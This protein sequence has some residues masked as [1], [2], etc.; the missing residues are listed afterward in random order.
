MSTYLS[1]EQKTFIE[2]LWKNEGK[3]AVKIAEELNLSVWTVRRLIQR[4]KKT[5]LF[6]P[7]WVAPIAE[8]ETV[9]LLSYLM[10]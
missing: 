7:K 3:N 8:Q 10:R 1:M 2:N 9:L 5:I 6:L 4:L